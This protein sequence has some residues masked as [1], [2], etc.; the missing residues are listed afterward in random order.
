MKDASAYMDLTNPVQSFKTRYF[1]MH[2]VGR[3][4][5]FSEKLCE[6]RTIVPATIS[7]PTFEL[8]AI[9]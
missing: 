4:H 8:R 2:M 7:H 3:S 5:W 9:V 6:Q 1:Q